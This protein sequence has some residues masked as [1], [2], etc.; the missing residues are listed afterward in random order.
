MDAAALY[1]LMTWL[2]PSFPVG[3][4]SY[5]HGL[6]YAVEAGL[7]WNRTTLED[8]VKA[9]IQDGSGHIDAILFCAAYRA[10][11]ETEG[12]ASW[13]LPEVVETAQAMRGS[14]EQMVESQDQGRA[15]LDAVRGAWPSPE[16]ERWAQDLAD[17]QMAPA[18]PVA[19][20]FACAVNQIPMEIALSAYLHA[21]VASLVSAGMR[22]IP[23]GQMD[24][25]KVMAALEAPV[26]TA[27]QVALGCPL[28][29]LGA[30]TPMVDWTSMRHETQYT[31]LFRS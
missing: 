6:E 8:W 25:Q 16:L 20:A 18:Y 15:F 11:R 30:A 26:I 17:R 24:G 14:A 9:I 19:V 10:F 1:R 5:S 4:Y 7:V 12:S 27:T 23:L 3:S 22:L 31:R 2:S 13:S 21:F 29:D 28:E